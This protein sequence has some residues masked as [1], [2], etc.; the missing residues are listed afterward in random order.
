MYEI[1]PEV[2]NRLKV[3]QLE[4]IFVLNKL[5]LQ[6][7][8]INGPTTSVKTQRMRTLLI[9]N[10]KLEM[11]LKKT[12]DIYRI[13]K[14]KDFSWALA[15]DVDGELIKKKIEETNIAEVTYGLI[16]ADKLNLL[17][18]VFFDSN[19]TDDSL[20]NKQ[21][22][23][24]D[25]KETNA[26]ET[27]STIAE[28]RGII[29]TLEDKNR[30]LTINVKD[31]RSDLSKSNQENKTLG[32]KLKDNAENFG[33]I[34]KNYLQNKEILNLTKEELVTSEEANKKLLSENKQLKLELQN[35]S[36]LKILFYGTKYYRRLIETKTE[37]IQNLQYEYVNDLQQVQN[38]K[39]Y[40][41][42]IVLTFTLNKTEAQELN[43]KE[44]IKHFEELY[45]LVTISS[46]EQL[47]EYITKVGH[48]NE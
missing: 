23:S 40:Q 6:G 48:Y 9:N 24:T 33:K 2:I 8:R 1:L 35:T 22:I 26:N 21:T 16:E 19:K 32:Q 7:F 25:D 31:L 4:E 13:Q 44:A 12:A 46:L 5:N 36:N 47:N 37:E 27:N 18:E 11:V 34:N 43:D 17:Q 3:N 45:N 20:E 28:L 29:N 14:N 39:Q 41:K 15:S 30:I 10:P 42:L 38:Y